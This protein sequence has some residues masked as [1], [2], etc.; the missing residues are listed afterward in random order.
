[1]KRGRERALFACDALL[2]PLSRQLGGDSVPEQSLHALGLV[3]VLSAPDPGN[4]PAL[5]SRGPRGLLGARLGA[6]LGAACPL[7]PAR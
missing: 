4:V 1:M 7:A 2:L 5:C 6:R 3:L